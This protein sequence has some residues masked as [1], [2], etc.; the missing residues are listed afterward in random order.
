L[1]SHFEERTQIDD[2]CLDYETNV[3]MMKE[4]NT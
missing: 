1:V 2:I 3:D 4:L